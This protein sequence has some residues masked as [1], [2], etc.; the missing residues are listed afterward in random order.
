MADGREAVV[1]YSRV[2]SR[3]RSTALAAVDRQEPRLD[4]AEVPL[5]DPHDDVDPAFAEVRPEPRIEPIYAEVSREAG[6]RRGSM[7]VVIAGAA[8]AMLAGVGVLAGTIGV[9]TII[10]D[11]TTADS[12]PVSEPALRLTNAEVVPDPAAE[13][14]TVRKIPLAAG[15]EAPA[16][17]AVTA[18][19]LPRPR[20]EVKTAS[21]EPQTDMPVEPAVAKAPG[22]QP[23]GSNVGEPAAKVAVLPPPPQ[24]AAPP[25]PQGTDELITN[26][27]QTLQKIDEAPAGAA[28][29]DVAAASPAVLPPPPLESSA[30]ALP[31]SYP[32]VDDGCAPSGDG[33][34]PCYDVM[35][36]EPITNGY[37]VP[38]PV[39]P[40]P[41][42]NPYP[43]VSSDRDAGWG[44]NSAPGGDGDRSASAGSSA[45]GDASDE[46]SERRGGIVRRAVTRTADAVSRVLGRD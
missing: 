13:P 1:T 43:S 28:P 8:F 37:Y 11:D 32:P 30:L 15:E 24:P 6:R 16:A 7:S 31:P 17:E 5:L 36:P 40:E 41:I 20:P 26:I 10:P 2:P 34:D 25:Q 39:P 33:F 45:S 9:A 4:A 22:P 3:A 46:S 19:P 42:P 21:V 27:E 35:P 23:L 29:N 38:G 12:A 14:A 44:G 18:P